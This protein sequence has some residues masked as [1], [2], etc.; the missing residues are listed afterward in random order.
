LVGFF[1]IYLAHA[2]PAQ[3]PRHGA[4]RNTFR[5]AHDQR[6]PQPRPTKR[7]ELGL[8]ELFKLTARDSLRRLEPPAHDRHGGASA[9]TQRL[10]R[11]SN[12]AAPGA[13]ALSRVLM[14]DLGAHRFDQLFLLERYN[15]Q[16]TTQALFSRRYFQQVLFDT[17]RA[18]MRD[19]PQSDAGRLHHSRRRHDHQAHPRRSRYRAASPR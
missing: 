1:L 2:A 12:G 5:L 10:L 9:G 4:T 19:L 11:R 6:R 14:E 15:Q 7:G 3:S 16:D 17:V 13:D 18:T 8:L